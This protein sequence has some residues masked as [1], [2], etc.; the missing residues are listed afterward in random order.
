M[1]DLSSTVNG[2]AKAAYQ[3][4]I[5]RANRTVVNPINNVIDSNITEV[6]TSIG[7][8]IIRSV[9]GKFQ[10]SI[11]FTIGINY[12]DRWMEEALYGILYEYNDIKKSSEL[13]LSNKDSSDGSTMYYR[14]DDG[15]HSLKYRNYK[16]MVAISTKTN[17][18]ASGRSSNV[19]MYQ[20]ITY[21]LSPQFVKDFESDMIKYRNSL[22]KIKKDSP[23]VAVYKDYHE[24]DGYTYW[25]KTL[26]IPKRKLSTVYMKKDDRE[27]L[28]NTINEF[29]A[30]KKMYTEHGI[31]HNL[32]ILLYGPPGSGKDSIAKMIASE[33]NRNIFYVTGGKNG[34]FI[35]NALTDQ[36]SEIVD[37]LFLISDIDKY[38]SIINEMDIKVSKK[39]STDG[40]IKEETVSQKQN[41]A[42]MINALDGILSGDD[43]IIVMTTNHIE[44]FSKTF[45]RPGRV[46]LMMYIGYVDVEMFRKFVWDH[47]NVAL[48]TSIK[49]NKDNYTVSQM[50]FDVLFM[51]MP[52][53]AFVDKYAAKSNK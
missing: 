9:R 19:R 11:T 48:P 40:E 49:L 39:G 12:Y 26:T 10:R 43:K 4:T 29:F 33:W 36:S 3:S 46:D 23:T 37:P 51:K 6:A 25:E 13:E 38:P 7:G 5:D 31:S 22:L 28:V 47:Y 35:P 45:L 17:T 2:V 34:K 18:S 30:N 1:K 32:K 24:G 16:I 52:V 41:F 44:K 42:N 50:Q 20:I 14:L 53:Q 8:F 15:V 21:N 27:K